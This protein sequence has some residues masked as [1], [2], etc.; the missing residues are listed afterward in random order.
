MPEVFL[1]ILNLIVDNGHAFV[2]EELLHEIGSAKMVLAG[3]HA[4][5]VDDPVGGNILRT[6]IHR[7]TDHTRG[8]RGGQ[9]ICDGAV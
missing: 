3:E 1:Q 5:A 4:V 6:G 7:P 8:T 9:M 2:F